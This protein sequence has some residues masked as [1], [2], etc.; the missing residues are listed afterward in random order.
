MLFILRW[1]LPVYLTIYYKLYFA[2]LHPSYATKPL[3]FILRWYLPV[4]MG[5]S[6]SCV[7]FP[8]TANWWSRSMDSFQRTATYEGVRRWLFVWTARVR[9]MDGYIGLLH[10]RTL[11]AC[12]PSPDNS[13]VCYLCKFSIWNRP[14]S[15]WKS[16][17]SLMGRLDIPDT[18]IRPGDTKGYVWC[19]SF[20]SIRPNITRDSSVVWCTLIWLISKVIYTVSMSASVLWMEKV[21]VSWLRRDE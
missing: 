9:T 14:L 19:V 18:A 6:P 10:H 20:H 12:I 11:A 8:D 3:F 1:Y 16:L 15:L 21:S 5:Q 4:S 13:G 7:H 2:T 17:T